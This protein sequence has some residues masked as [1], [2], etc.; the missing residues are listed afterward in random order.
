MNIKRNRKR[1]CDFIGFTLSFDDD[2]TR[3]LSHIAPFINI[4]IDEL[5]RTP[6][7]SNY[8]QFMD[9]ELAASQFA[10]KEIFLKN[11]RWR[12][13]DTKLPIEHEDIGHYLA[14]HT[15]STFSLNNLTRT[16]SSR[17]RAA[18]KNKVLNWDDLDRGHRKILAEII[19]VILY[20]K[21][22]DPLP[23]GQFVWETNEA[24]EERLKQKKLNVQSSSIRP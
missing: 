19:M 12:A 11:K 23:S 24:F 13:M 20:I 5:A 6:S 15:L 9:E 10:N 21:S 22:S 4:L 17:I 2:V 3:M 8:H 1:I 7:Y 18:Q 16:V 14:Q